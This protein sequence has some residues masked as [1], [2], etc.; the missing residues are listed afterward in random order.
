M[1]KKCI[2]I[3]ICIYLFFYIFNY[4]TPMGFGDDYLYSFVWQGKPEFIPLNA[5][6]VRVSSLHDLIVSQWSHY[7]T[8]SGRTVNHTLAQLFLWF[9]KDI[10]NFF[11]A[12]VATIL[13]AEIYWCVNRG[14][15]TGD[16]KVHEV[17]SIFF[18]LWAFTP[19]FVSVFLWLDGACNYLWTTVFLLAFL[20]PYIHKYFFLSSIK[21]NDKIFSVTMFIAGVFTGWT[22]ENSICWIIVVLTFF[23][24]KTHK[25][26]NAEIWMFSG[27]TGL[28]F[29]YMLLILA[30]GNIARLYAVHGPDWIC[31]KSVGNVV[32]NFLQGFL[33]VSLF[34]FLLWYT[35]FKIY[36][37]IQKVKLDS[38]LA[39]K[40]IVLVKVLCFSAFCMSAIM[41]VSPEFPLRS[42]FPGTVQLILALGILINCHKKYI[43]SV[44]LSKM[45]KPLF[46][47]GCIYFLM[48][49]SVSFYYLYS[50]DVQNQNL[51]AYVKK[52]RETTE[53]IILNIEPFDKPGRL[54]NLLSGFHIIENELTENEDSW[55][56]VSFSRYYDIKGIQV[57]RKE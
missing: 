33:K 28:F 24:F 21:S 46:Y 34:Q 39:H 42:G 37:K 29:G 5:D 49:A 2:L 8:W 50:L 14:C 53:D 54:A 51:I 18:A 45:G 27:L 16:F 1:S 12:L 13:I 23:V 4:F 40:D 56:N 35:C 26:R 30:P 52:E 47:T 3:L 22:N 7:F 48:T 17:L 10:F 6:A 25:C 31:T 32:G 20:L 57:K 55:E 41:I 19:G 44:F 11:N 38:E 36:R 15:I 9:G 43:E